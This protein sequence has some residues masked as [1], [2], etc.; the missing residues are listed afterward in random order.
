MGLGFGVP[1]RLGCLWVRTTGTPFY[2]VNRG[3]QPTEEQVEN[4]FR[5]IAE[6]L[7]HGP[8]KWLMVIRPVVPPET[9]SCGADLYKV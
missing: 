8:Q 7:Y 6:H 9:G 3:K 2:R 5:S 4:H 1:F